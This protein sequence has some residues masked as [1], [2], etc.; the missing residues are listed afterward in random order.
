MRYGLSDVRGKQFFAS[1]KKDYSYRTVSVD[2]TT[3]MDWEGGTI[4]TIVPTIDG[5]W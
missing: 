2:F 4:G 1:Q 5:P 3:T